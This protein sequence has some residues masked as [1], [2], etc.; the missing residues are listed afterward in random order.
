VQEGC[1]VNAECYKGVLDC[2]I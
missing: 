1:P 2:L